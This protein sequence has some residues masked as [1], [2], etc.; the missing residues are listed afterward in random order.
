MSNCG[1]NPRGALV[2]PGADGIVKTIRSSLAS[3]T[4]S[5]AATWPSRARSVASASVAVT[6][7]AKR[8][9]WRLGRDLG[10]QA[11]PTAGGAHD[12]ERAAE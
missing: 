2:E 1:P 6:F 4:L 10:P 12:F 11:R 9:L 8:S 7:L 5:L 3:S